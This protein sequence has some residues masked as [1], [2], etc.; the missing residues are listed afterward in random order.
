MN[1]KG[2]KGKKAKQ[3]EVKN[4]FESINSIGS[5]TTNT[6]KNEAAAIS[7]DFFRQLLNQQKVSEVKRSGELTNGTLSSMKEMRSGESE[8]LRK[9]N[10]QL[11]NERRLHQEEAQESSRKLQELRIRLHAIQQEATKMVNSTVSLSAEIKNAVLTGSVDPSEYHVNFL[12]DIIKVMVGFRKKIDTA[13]AWL[14]STNKRAQKKNYWSTYKKKGSSFLLSPDHYL[15]R[16]A[17]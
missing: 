3:V 10:E 13:T 12:E 8:K 5:Q 16:S 6:I 14:S 2:Q 11:N 1:D 4:F 15:Q 7:E 17:G 9:L